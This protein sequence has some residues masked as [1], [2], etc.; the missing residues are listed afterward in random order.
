MV[1]VRIFGD[2]LF[3]KDSPTLSGVTWHWQLWTYRIGGA[4]S[5]GVGDDAFVP[6]HNR[7]A[8]LERER[9]VFKQISVSKI[10]CHC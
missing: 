2:L 6:K 8:Y 3:S 7:N 4:T 5:G 1:S 10:F 9:S